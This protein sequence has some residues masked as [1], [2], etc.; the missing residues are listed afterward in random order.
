MSQGEIVEFEDCATLFAHPNHEYTKQL[1]S[2]IPRP[3]LKLH[4]GTRAEPDA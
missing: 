4:H 3:G 1:L 2:A